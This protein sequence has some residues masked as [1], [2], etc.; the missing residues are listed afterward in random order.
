MSLRTNNLRFSRSSL[1]LRTILFTIV[2]ASLAA[3]MNFVLISPGPVTK[4][5]PK[6][7]TI[8]KAAGVKT[9]PVNGQLELLTIYVTNPE[10]KVL[11]A[12]VLGC[13]VK[14]DCVALP[15]VVMYEDGTTDEKETKA[16]KKDMVKSQNVALVAAVA[17]IH[18][19]FPQVTLRDIK[20]SDVKVSLKNTGGPS[21]GLIFTLG[22]IDIITPQDLLKGRT[23]AGTGTIAADGSIGAIGGVTEKILGARKAGASILFISTENCSELPTQVEGISVIAIEKIDQA[24]K[25]LQAPLKSFDSAG[26][27]GCASVG[28]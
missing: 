26:I 1:L 13:W 3:P 23:I 6:V 24:V 21:G 11:G 22:L 8:D 28:A 14:G 25:Y 18:R 10:T 12:E 19:K 5:F 27:R 16:G 17:A 4:L 2:I 20:D 15:R 9:Y 7:L